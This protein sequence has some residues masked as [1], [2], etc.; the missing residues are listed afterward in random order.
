MLYY[1]DWIG[2]GILFIQDLLDDTGRIMNKQDV[3]DKLNRQIQSL[4]CQS[5]ISAISPE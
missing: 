3:E 2:Q 5:L 4:H 1:K